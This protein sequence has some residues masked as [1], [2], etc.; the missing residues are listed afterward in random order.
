MSYTKSKTYGKSREINRDELL[1]TAL[2]PLRALIPLTA[3]FLVLAM[4]LLPSANAQQTVDE[5][6]ISYEMLD[7]AE[8]DQVLAPIALYPDSLLSQ[9]LVASTYPLEVL[10]ATRW[11]QANPD[12]SEDA[13]LS[14]VEDKEWD[15]SVKALA[16]FE[17]LLVRITEDLEWLQKLGDAFLQNEDQ[18]LAS[19]QNL[20]QKA[21]EN[22]SL[23]DNDYLEI[24]QEDDN[25]IIESTNTEIV[26]VPYYDTR[27]VYGPWWWYSYQPV[28]WHRPAHYNYYRHGGFYFSHGFYVRPSLFYGGFHW[29]TRHLVVNHYYYD[30]GDRYKY[31]HSP[32]NVNIS[33]YSHWSHD[34]IH[35]RGV[36][37]PQAVIKSNGSL[38][39]SVRRTIIKNVETSSNS[40]QPT[41]NGHIKTTS[42]T[43]VASNPQQ[44]NANMVQR[45]L[46]EAKSAVKSGQTVDKSDTHYR[47]LR[48]ANS[49]T[50]TTTNANPKNPVSRSND[51]AT[52]NTTVRSVKP[53]VTSSPK[54]RLIN[55]QQTKTSTTPRVVTPRNYGSG[56]SNYNRAGSNTNSSSTPSSSTPKVSTHSRFPKTS[57]QSNTSGTKTLN[58]AQSIRR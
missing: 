23:A 57:Q 45:K 10:Q 1:L 24:N 17:D 39:D 7:Q 58:K 9:I 6:S 21:H 33:H 37:Y 8:L 22:G 13:V 51:T 56:S 19:V 27:E 49:S 30:R 52:R 43:S 16:P 26:Y 55:T 50:K 28:Y 2:M 54:S 29:R 47:S 46:N 48:T 5:Q 25:I 32:R 36:R 38:A 18:V 20:R 31:G 3:L 15:P 42:R 35:R 41:R 44:M 11:R 4:S 34:P 14:A 40:V 12:L 53:T